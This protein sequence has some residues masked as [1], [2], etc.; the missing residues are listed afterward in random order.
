MNV[1][2][3]SLLVAVASLAS[4]AASSPREAVEYTNRS[5]LADDLLVIPINGDRLAGLPRTSIKGGGS[6]N[7]NYEGVL[8]S[9]LLAT[10]HASDA[11]PQ[12]RMASEYVVVEGADGFRAVFSMAECDTRFGPSTILIAD[13]VDGQP[14]DVRHG[15]F[16][17]IAPGDQLP[18]RWVR[19]VTTVRVRS[20]ASLP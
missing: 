1:L 13:R 6:R 8:L 7:S 17:L 9:D 4:C 16:R 20:V 19:G 10:R 12:R 3:L 14:L 18:A 5:A 11:H 2:R 15:Q